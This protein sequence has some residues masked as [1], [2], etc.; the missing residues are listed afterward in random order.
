MEKAWV[1]DGGKVEQ[2]AKIQYNEIGEA[3]VFTEDEKKQNAVE[4]KQ[5]PRI[6]F[7]KHTVL[8]VFSGEKPNGG[9]SVKIERVVKPDNADTP[10]IVIY[11]E[12][13]PAPDSMNTMALV[14]PSNVVVIAKTN[15]KFEFIEATS[16]KGKQLLE[17]LNKK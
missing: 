15:A 13:T 1:A 6:D 11:R 5:S 16:V 7:E 10:N 9:Y 17:A 14:Y 4:G 12:G 8:A 3:K 2:I